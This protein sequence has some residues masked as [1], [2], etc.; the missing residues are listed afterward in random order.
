MAHNNAD[1]QQQQQ[2]QQM[3]RRTMSM[4]ITPVTPTPVPMVSSL[5][6]T[7]P[8]AKKRQTNFE[9][10][11]TKPNSQ[12]L[13]SSI[14]LNSSK[15]LGLPLAPPTVVGMPM[16]TVVQQQ[17][18][19]KENNHQDAHPASGGPM[20]LAAAI[21]S[22]KLTAISRRRESMCGSRQQALIHAI[23]LRKWSR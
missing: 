10:E 2:Q 17:Q 20:S 4:C 3:R 19:R 8:T 22:G 6:G 11:L 9:Q 18:H 13:S 5:L 21:A 23:S 12:I 15:G 16:P 7:P 1:Q 14:L